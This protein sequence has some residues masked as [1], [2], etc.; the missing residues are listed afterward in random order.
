MT[1][2]ASVFDE[3]MTS[4]EMSIRNAPLLTVSPEPISAS[5]DR[6]G[7]MWLGLA[8][9]NV[10]GNTSEGLTPRDR[11][12]EHG[13]IRDFRGE[14]NGV[15]DGTSAAWRPERRASSAPYGGREE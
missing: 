11:K 4:G 10:L 13:E 15:F 12:Q 6:V 8:I 2:S 7:G 3:M 1:C 9:G 14:S 5:W